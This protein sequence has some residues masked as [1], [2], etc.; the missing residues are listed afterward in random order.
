M[1]SRLFRLLRV[2]ATRDL[3]HAQGVKEKSTGR[4]VLICVLLH[5]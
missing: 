2:Q 3:C 4:R 5:E 1:A